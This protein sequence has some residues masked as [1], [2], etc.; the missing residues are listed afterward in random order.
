MALI[1]TISGSVGAGGALTSANAITGTLVI[2]NVTTNFPTLPSDTVF[3]VSGSTSGTTTQSVFGGG[4]VVSGNI[5]ARNDLAVNGDDITTATT[6]TFNF[7]NSILTGTLNIGA[8]ATTI[9]VGGITTTSSY[10]GDIAVAGRTNVTTVVERIATS[11]GGTGTVSFDLGVQGIFYVNN[12][13][14]NI[15]ANF[16]NVPTTT[17]RVI[18][19]TVILSQSIG[20]TRPIVSAV[21]VNGSSQTI[22]WAN[23]VTPTGNS[24]K[25]DVFGFSLI[26]SGSGGSAVWKVLG[27]MSTY[28]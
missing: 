21:Q 15:T 4:L 11:N 6:T 10:A 13:T 27:Q 26:R 14:G 22:D 16:T 17:S 12:P 20:A 3:L 8:A 7:L 1:G 23:G 9:N 24:G 2:A 19:P 5:T 18:T 28:G 25:Q